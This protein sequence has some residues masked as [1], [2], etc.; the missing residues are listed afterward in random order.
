[1]TFEPQN[2]ALEFHDSQVAYVESRGED[3]IIHL[4][5]GYV[6]RSD[7]HPGV[8]VGAGY[9]APISIRFANAKFV[10]DLGLSIGLL[11][12]GWICLGEVKMTL[13]PLPYQ[14]VGKVS[15]TLQFANGTGLEVTASAVE[16]ALPGDA[17]FVESYSC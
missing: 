13:L 8:D 14:G 17:K 1:M 7:G 5:A 4:A 15:A 10:G 6:H 16:C 12:D 3:L 2:S 11:W 9:L